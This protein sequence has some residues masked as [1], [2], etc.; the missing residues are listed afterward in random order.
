[1]THSLEVRNMSLAMGRFPVLRDISFHVLPGEYLSVVGPNGAGK[2]T[3]LK[4]LAGLLRGEGEVWIDGQSL[5]GL[6][7]RTVAR[8]VGYVPQSLEVV[9]PVTVYDFLMMGR[10]SFQ[11]AFQRTSHRDR[12]Q[13]QRVLEEL[14]L[15]HLSSR[16]LPELSGGE[17]QKVHIGA[18]LVQEPR[19]LF[20]DEPTSFLDPCQEEEI[21]SLLD[22]LRRQRELTIVAVTHHLNSSVLHADRILALRCGGVTF[23][24]S[25]R[26]FMRVETLKSVY[27]IDFTLVNH[28]T[29]S[30]PM[31]L[32]G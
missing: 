13:V 1:M 18:A 21:L 6:S 14:S 8:I 15:S 25:A 16:A 31:V 28:P 5:T 20:L 10:Y 23:L 24:G 32:P 29:R 26:E 11:T 7:R 22:R 27:G 19:I 9:F 2:T 3:L 12:E 17:R 30:V 4:C